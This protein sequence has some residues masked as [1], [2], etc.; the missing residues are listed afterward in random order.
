MIVD[1]GISVHVRYFAAAADAAGLD[2]ETLTLA[3]G[4]TVSDLI[5]QVG[6]SHR[7]EL[8]QVLGLCS[9]LLDGKAVE[10]DYPLASHSSQ[11]VRLDVLPPFA[12]G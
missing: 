2:E 12:G 11:D 1:M 9:F 4:S 8:T 7:A 5:T 10:L 3:P 6:A